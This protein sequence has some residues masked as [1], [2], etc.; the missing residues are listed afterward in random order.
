MS[1]VRLIDGNALLAQVDG[2]FPDTNHTAVFITHCIRN[3]PTVTQQPADGDAISREAAIAA[4]RRD[5]MCYS[6]EVNADRQA[7]QDIRMLENLPCIPSLPV[8]TPA[9]DV[10][11]VTA[12]DVVEG[13]EFR[14]GDGVTRVQK[15]GVGWSMLREDGEE[16]ICL[17]DAMVAAMLN[18]AESVTWPEGHPRNPKPKQPTLLEAAEAFM[19]EASTRKRI[20]TGEHGVCAQRLRDLQA[21]IKREKGGEQT[22]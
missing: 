13:M 8:A 21:A 4:I 7:E 11:R 14:I 15:L 16:L 20:R 19:R 12:E 17:P 10:D 3:A 6:L 1:S 22:K 5:Q 2:T 18:A 9:Q